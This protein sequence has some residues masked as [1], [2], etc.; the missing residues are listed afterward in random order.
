M[1]ARW[2]A[3]FLVAITL[4]VGC[5]HVGRIEG[6]DLTKLR[7]GMT[8]QEVVDILGPPQNASANKNI[9]T[10]RYFQDRGMYRLTYHELLFEDGKLKQYG[11]PNRP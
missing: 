11:V 9:E 4:M 1:R 2:K 7:L 3:L 5:Q 6:S 10:Y 8:K